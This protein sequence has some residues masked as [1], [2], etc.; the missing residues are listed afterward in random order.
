MGYH[1]LSRQSEGS[2]IGLSIVKEL[3]KI[4]GG[5][6]RAD[7]LVGK[8]TKIVFNLSK[9]LKPSVGFASSLNHNSLDKTRL[10][11]EFSDVE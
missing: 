5:T 9:S 2:G 4:H 11:M 7:S 6:I 1:G 10:K 8:E 3:V